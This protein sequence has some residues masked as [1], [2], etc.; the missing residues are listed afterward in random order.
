MKRLFASVISLA[1]VAAILPI[2]AG[3][4]DART[5]V[6]KDHIVEKIDK[7]IGEFKVRRKE[8]EL[9]IAKLERS[10]KNLKEGAV[11]SEVKS[12]QF[13]REIEEIDG[14]LEQYKVALGTLRD[15][16]SSSAEPIVMSGKE[17]TKDQLKEMSA[18]VIKSHKNATTI[19]DG[20]QKA[21]DILAASAEKLN[22][23]QE[24]GKEQ[25]AIMEAQLDE[26]DAKLIAVNSIRE[27]AELAGS[28]EATLSE[29]FEQVQGQINDLFAKVEVASALE[30]EEV[31]EAGSGID[32]ILKSTGATGGSIDDIDAIL[33]N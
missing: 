9:N 24:K 7:A 13:G 12:K 5:E 1:A 2:F 22:K 15:H 21:K 10:L 25:I 8:I 18:K 28:D 4:G 29:N 6:I 19:R 31:E 16:L 27:S 26:I 23:R 11:T 3:C 14:A 30:F 17:Y 32:D 20:K 33:N